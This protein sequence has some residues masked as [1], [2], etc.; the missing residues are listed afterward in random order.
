MTDKNLCMSRFLSFRFVQEEDLNFFPGLK[1]SVWRRPDSSKCET[2]RDSCD[3]DR[4]VRR[5]V[6]PFVAGGKTAVFLSG[7]IDSAILASY[8]PAGTKAYT[9]K[10]VAEGAV[11]E[12]EQARRYADAYGLD[13]EV[14]EMHWSDF[15]ALTPELLRRD[16][17]PFHSI[18]VQLL[19]GA[20]VAKAAGYD[21]LILGDGADTLFGG[22]DGFLAK[23]RTLEEFRERFAYVKP[24]KALRHPVDVTDV[25]RRFLRSDGTIDAQSYI[26]DV[27]AIESTCSYMH[28]FDQSGLQILAPYCKMRLG[29]DLDVERIRAG[30]PK[31]ILR[32]LFS[33]RYPDIE[34]P[35]KIP[36]PR[37]TDQWLADWSGPQRDEFLPDCHVGMT[38]DQKWLVWCLEQ[39][40]NAYDKGELS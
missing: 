6:E 28:A 5:C 35:R 31:Y 17:V 12:V 4:V 15:E 16:G 8:L 21:R 25:Y 32:E 24:E 29:V 40:L 23:D 33:R 19:K 37:A 7:G 26:S 3:V 34:I 20:R 22:L 10:C 11:S 38:G 27:F 13:H 14:I 39:F 30:E 36:L 2:V 9:F 18:E 1:H